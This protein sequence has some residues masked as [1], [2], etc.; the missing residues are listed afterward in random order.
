MQKKPTSVTQH[1]ALISEMLH[2]VITIDKFEM[3][4]EKNNLKIWNIEHGEHKLMPGY[5]ANLRKSYESANHSFKIRIL[6]EQGL[7]DNAMNRLMALSFS[8]PDLTVPV[9]SIVPELPI[10]DHDDDMESVWHKN[11]CGAH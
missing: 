3:M 7:Y 5:F 1:M 6:E 9:L 4:I 10:I 11:R 2:A 8:G